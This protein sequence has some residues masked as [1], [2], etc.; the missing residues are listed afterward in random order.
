[1]MTT[2]NKSWRVTRRLITGDRSHRRHRVCCSVDL[3]RRIS[4]LTVML[5]RGCEGQRGAI[6]NMEGRS[7][8]PLGHGEDKLQ[9]MPL[10]KL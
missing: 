5:W 3:E 4:P 2:S 6:L 9:A 8:Q 7:N 1:M 10:Q